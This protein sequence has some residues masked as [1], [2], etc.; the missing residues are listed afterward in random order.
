MWA[1]VESSRAARHYLVQGGRRR[2]AATARLH[3]FGLDEAAANGSVSALRGYLENYPT[4]PHLD[5]ARALIHQRFATALAAI[6]DHV[7]DPVALP[8]MAALLDHLERT[9]DPR[10]AVHFAPADIATLVAVD[11][12]VGREAQE[13]G[14]HVAPATPHV[15]PAELA[16]RETA[17]ARFLTTGLAALVPG[18]VL[19]LEVAAAAPPTDAPALE[20]AYHLAAMVDGDGLVFFSE[21]APDQPR[22]ADERLYLG[23]E[24]TFDVTI[25]VPSVPPFT[26]PVAV[27]PP[28]RFDVRFAHARYQP[29]PATPDGDVYETMISRAFDRL[30]AALGRTLVGAPEAPAAADAPP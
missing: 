20:V 2:A 13:R 27:A 28:D 23:I 25:K 9:G 8:A 11:E 4:S 29:S 21:G 26:V 16:R 22:E 6:R 19:R 3:R 18:D 10:V 1:Q 7:A 30:G 5:E 15:Q 14:I 24:I 12:L 17:I